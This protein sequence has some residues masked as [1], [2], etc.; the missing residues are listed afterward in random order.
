MESVAKDYS[1]ALL[2]VLGV[3]TLGMRKSWGNRRANGMKRLSSSVGDICG[4]AY[5]KTGTPS[6]PRP[7]GVMEGTGAGVVPFPSLCPRWFPG[8][9]GAGG[10]AACCWGGQRT[11]A[12]RGEVGEWSRGL[13]KGKECRDEKVRGE[14]RSSITVYKD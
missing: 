10:G 14:K 2:V 11:T 8:V 13:L 1:T 3:C 5:A 9:K 12:G 6:G 7:T 4:W